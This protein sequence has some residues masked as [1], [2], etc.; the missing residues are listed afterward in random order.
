MLHWSEG[1][2]TSLGVLLDGNLRDLHSAAIELCTRY[3]AERYS[4]NA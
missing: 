3:V 2:G 4:G 1:G